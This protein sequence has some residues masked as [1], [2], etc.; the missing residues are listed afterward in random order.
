LPMGARIRDLERMPDGRLAAS[1][2]DGRLLL[3]G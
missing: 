3:I 1:T 2:D